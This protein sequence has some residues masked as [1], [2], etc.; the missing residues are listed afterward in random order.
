MWRNNYQILLLTEC[1]IGIKRLHLRTELIP[2]SVYLY[3]APH[4]AFVVIRFWV[5]G[6]CS[7][8]L[9]NRNPALRK[10]ASSHLTGFYWHQLT[11][12][13]KWKS[14]IYF[15]LSSRH[16]DRSCGYRFFVQVTYSSLSDKHPS[17]KQY[18]LLVCRRIEKLQKATDSFVTSVCLSTW[19][20]SSA[21]GQVFHKI[22]YCNVFRKL[23]RKFKFY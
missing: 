3:T 17:P 6:V 1:E 22:W 10:K 16:T 5:I 7:S 18:I 11:Q 23:S 9:S 14:A 2:H 8:H 4:R 20:S 13:L 12:F 19:N 15:G 21:T